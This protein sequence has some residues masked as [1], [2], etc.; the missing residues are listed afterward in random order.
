MTHIALASL[1][2]RSGAKSRSISNSGSIALHKSPDGAE[3][4]RNPRSK[5]FRRL[6][7]SGATSYNHSMKSPLLYQSPSQTPSG[8]SFAIAIS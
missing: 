8:R 6:S 5:Q 7:I 2:F 3:G 1:F 4:F